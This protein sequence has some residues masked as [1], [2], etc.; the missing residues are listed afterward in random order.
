M[1]M[2]RAARPIP[3]ANMR[4]AR[5]MAG[6][7]PAM[8]AGGPVVPGV[9]PR[10]SR[11][12]G[13]FRGALA[14]WLPG[15]PA[16]ATMWRERQVAST[17]SEDL[18]ANDWAASSLVSNITLNAV[19]AN[20]LMPSACIPAKMLGIDE[21]LAREIGNAMEDVWW[22]WSERAGYDGQPFA[23][24]Q[25]MG[26]H[27]AIVHGEMVQV[28]VMVDPASDGGFLGLRIQPVHSQRMC[29]PA[30]KRGQSNFR[31]G[32]E[33]DAHGRRYAGW[34][35]EPNPSLFTGMHG[36]DALGSGSFRRLPYRVGHR[37]GLFHCFRHTSEEQYRG[38]PVITPAL[39][40][41][42]HLADSLEYEL[43]G[44]IVAASFP[45]VFS[46]GRKG[47]STDD[48]DAF[49]RNG[50]GVQGPQGGPGDGRE[51]I[52]HQSYAPGQVL[53]TNEGEDAKVLSSD[54]PGANWNSFVT[55]IVRAMGASAGL[56]YEAVLKDFS[57]T[58][59]S[60]ARAAL[61]EAWRVYMMWRQWQARSYCQPIWRMVQ[62]E[63]FL[64]G[65]IKLPP[66]APGFYEALPLWTAANWI[67]PGRGYVDPVKEADAAITMLDN[68]LATY[69]E[70][71]GERGLD[72]EDVWALRGHEDRML[73]RLAPELAERI[74]SR[75]GAT[76][77]RGP[78]P[79]DPPAQT[80][81]QGH[82][83]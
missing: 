78:Y 60:S 22:L 57:K 23:D 67:G 50:G 39:K 73:H 35:A 10:V 79:S 17:R 27:S 40:L 72:V 77:Q 69:S 66:N 65:Y 4:R 8:R 6:Q 9:V 33:L 5:Q 24:L 70:I 82:A 52:Y 41:F 20:G 21:D 42:R 36:W 54:R 47:G 37:V 49:F 51:P 53:Y 74:N 3:H 29:T 18:T 58:N 2:P 7:M 64:R 28:P 38:E 15:R 16:P 55:F 12:A 26:M 45:L 13:S 56:P 30:D 75:T 25:Y 46:S 62:E 81:E 44:Q 63:A 71:L 1:A 32:V 59:Y 19:G 68:G 83:Q 34:I 61:L 48:M 76:A 43:I 80:Q 14:N 11:D 31:D